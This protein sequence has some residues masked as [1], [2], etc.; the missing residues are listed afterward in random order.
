MKK[1]IF[2]KTKISRNTSIKKINIKMF[3]RISKL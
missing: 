1:K 3:S 2:I